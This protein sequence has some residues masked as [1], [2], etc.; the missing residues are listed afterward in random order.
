MYRTSYRDM[1][2]QKPF[3]CKKSAIP[4]YA[5]HIPGFVPDNNFGNT[6][7]KM[8]YEQFNR[9]KYLSA[10]KTEFFPNRP[11][12]MNPYETKH[13]K[14]GGGL[15]DE[16]HCV[17]RLHGNSTITTNHPNYAHAEWVSITKSSFTP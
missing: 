8:T 12:T 2:K 9:Q 16:Y 4:G 1:S 13:G 5:G 17:S 7:T 10:P 11:V 14:F 6:F 15:A 3:G